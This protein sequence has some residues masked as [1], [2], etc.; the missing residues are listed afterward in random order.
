[1]KDLHEIN[2]TLLNMICDVGYFAPELYCKVEFTVVS[3]EDDIGISVDDLHRIK[4]KMTNTHPEICGAFRFMDVGDDG[5]PMEGSDHFDYDLDGKD[6]RGFFVRDLDELDD[7]SMELA[8][9]I[10]HDGV[11]LRHMFYPCPTTFEVKG[12]KLV[13]V[14]EMIDSALVDT[15]NEGKGSSHL[16]LQFKDKKDIDITKGM[17]KLNLDKLIS[18]KLY[19]SMRPSLVNMNTISAIHIPNR[20]KQ[21]PIV[22]STRKKNVS[23]EHHKE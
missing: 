23:F 12:N 13:M 1:M 19:F 16:L 6:I 9:V 7:S 20:S 18:A 22:A 15:I 2:P 5:K 3:L 10:F 17:M 8:Q 11:L 21:H 4:D 14:C